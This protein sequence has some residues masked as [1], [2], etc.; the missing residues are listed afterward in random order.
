MRV[1]VWALGT[2]TGHNMHMHMSHATCTCMSHAS[3]AHMHMLTCTCTCVGRD[4]LRSDTRVIVEDAQQHRVP[5][6]EHSSDAADGL[7]RH[8]GA[9]KRTPLPTKGSVSRRRFK[10]GLC[11]H[12]AQAQRIIIAPSAR[13]TMDVPRDV[14]S[15]C[16]QRGA[17]T[18]VQRDVAS[19]PQRDTPL[20]RDRHAGNSARRRTVRGHE[21]VPAATYLEG[22][23]EAL[24]R[25]KVVS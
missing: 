25:V 23:L 6:F 21:R 14:R 24:P 16:E 8:A 5:R 17:S 18:A 9:S 15:T 4:A 22:G 1:V 11:T 12:T 10:I 7:W 20:S 13:E 19:V 3:H 2:A